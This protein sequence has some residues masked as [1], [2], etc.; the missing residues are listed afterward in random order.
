MTP[1]TWREQKVFEALKKHQ[2]ED[3]SFPT[4]REIAAIVGIKS[5]SGVALCVEGLTRKGYLFRRPGRL[6]S[7]THNGRL[8]SL[9]PVVEEPTREVIIY[10]TPES[11]FSHYSASSGVKVTIRKAP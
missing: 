3:G 9:T 5:H 1:L 10:L 2:R 6:H 8:Y 4:M 7:N 11:R